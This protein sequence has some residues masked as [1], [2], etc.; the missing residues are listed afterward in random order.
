MT[1]TTR[2]YVAAKL[3]NLTV[4]DAAL[5]Y[6]G[7][8]TIDAH[9][10]DAAGIAPYEQLDVIN[11]ANGKRW[12][13]YALPGPA[14]AFTLNG[15]GARLGLLGDRCVVMTYAAT[16]GPFPGARAV[17]VDEHNAIVREI[18]YPHPADGGDWDELV[19]GPAPQ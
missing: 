17:F 7:S 10:L 8:V 4:T 12:T 9:L 11:L 16:D 6:V 15:G 19:D 5:S 14:G 13:T 18:S 1:T 2:T 3:H